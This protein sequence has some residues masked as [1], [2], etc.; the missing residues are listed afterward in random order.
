[1]SGHSEAAH[2][3]GREFTDG[4]KPEDGARLDLSHRLQ[5]TPEGVT[6]ELWTDPADECPYSPETLSALEDYIREHPKMRWLW[7]HPEAEV[8]I[9]VWTDDGVTWTFSKGELS[10]ATSQQSLFPG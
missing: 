6:C 8:S 9:A 7:R 2:W 1:M 5:I 3:A 10:D 4:L